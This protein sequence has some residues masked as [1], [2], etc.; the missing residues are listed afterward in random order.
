MNLLD[1]IPSPS[2][3]SQAVAYLLGA[4]AFHRC[5]YGVY[6]EMTGM[7]YDIEQGRNRLDEVVR[8]PGSRAY[9]MLVGEMRHLT[10]YEV[11]LD[12]L[13]LAA[14]GFLAEAANRYV[15]RAA[16]FEIVRMQERLSGIREF[17]D[18][19]FQDAASH[20]IG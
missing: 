16:E 14:R 11:G 20:F 2:Q 5:F 17:D 9:Q 12:D 13:E 10:G 1:S 8:N 15:G 3:P 4:V 7:G 6:D 19:S 18:R